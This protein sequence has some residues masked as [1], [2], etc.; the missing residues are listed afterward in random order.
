MDILYKNKKLEKL[1]NNIR[2][3]SK[4]YGFENAKKIM[5]RQQQVR[6]AQDLFEFSKI[7][8]STRC[9]ELHSKKGVDRRGQFSISLDGGSRLIFEPCD[10]PL[11]TGPDG[12]LIWRNIRAIRILGV[13][14]YHD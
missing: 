10:D 13:E 7:P 8:P 11:P 3:L 1:F 12:K 6:A 4:K 14:D 2:E 9:H 5:L